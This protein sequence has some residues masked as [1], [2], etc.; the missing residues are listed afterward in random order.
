MKKVTMILCSIIF[1]A[2]FSY[3]SAGNP[4][5]VV[6]EGIVSYQSE[7]SLPVVNEYDVRD[8]QVG[9][10]NQAQLEARSCSSNGECTDQAYAGIYINSEFSSSETV[11]S[12]SVTYESWG[13]DGPIQQKDPVDYNMYLRI[14]NKFN[15]STY[16]IEQET[17]GEGNIITHHVGEFAPHAN[18]TLILDLWLHH[19]DT[20]TYSDEVNARIHEIWT[21][22]GPSDTDA[23]GV[24]N[25]SDECPSTSYDDRGDVAEN[26]CLENSDADG[27]GIIDQNDLCS[28]TNSGEP[29]NENGCSSGQLDDDNDGVSNADDICPNTPQSETSNGVGCSASQRDADGD[30]V[31]DADDSCPDTESSDNV[32]SVG[33]SQSQLSSDD[34][35]DGVANSNDE[36]PDTTDNAEVDSNGC[37]IVYTDSDGDGYF[38][39]VDDEFPFD[40]SQWLDSDGDGYGDNSSGFNPDLCPNTF[41]KSTIDKLGCPDTD[42]DGYSDSGD[43]FPQNPTQYSDYDGDGYGDNIT[44]NNPDKFPEDATQH[45]DTDGDGYGDNSSGSNGDVCPLTY[46]SSTTDRFGCADEDN[47]GISDLNDECQNTPSSV[48][49][50]ELLPNGCISNNNSGSDELNADKVLENCNGNECADSQETTENL[51][52]QAKALAENNPIVTLTLTILTAAGTAFWATLNQKRRGKKAKKFYQ[53][54]RTAESLSKVVELRGQIDDMLADGKLDAPV[55]ENINKMLSQREAFLADQIHNI[56]SNE[57][58]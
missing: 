41:G 1:L 55:Y 4:A 12:V 53:L 9:T 7:N 3:T 51:A 26:G 27:D 40:G 32:N 42:Q 46:G 6:A 11:V 34:D 18:G 28:N 20:Y 8:G 57:D 58:N 2:M 43:A 14:E 23:D 37:E 25:S 10:Y 17:T 48:D 54:A 44:G 38:D 21:E 16:I 15:V 39:E 47:D 52:Q 35:G 30:G 13:E 24:P 36:C 56:G 5:T 50:T 22:T 45:E 29:V 49:I 33:C 31:S 19:T